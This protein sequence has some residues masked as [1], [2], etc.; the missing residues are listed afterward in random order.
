LP[1]PKQA[2][3]TVYPNDSKPYYN[4]S[5][6][7]I[8]MSKYL[9]EAQKYVMEDAYR[10]AGYQVGNLKLKERV[11]NFC[12]SHGWNCDSTTIH[13]PPVLQHYHTDYAANCGWMCSGNP[14]TSGG[15]FEPRGWG[16]SH[17]LG[18]N[19]QKFN[20]YNSASGEVSNNIYPL[21]KKWRLLI[22]LNRSNV[23]YLNELPDSAIVF[24]SLKATFKSSLT[25]EQKIAKAKNDIWMDS[26]SKSHLNRGMLYFYLQLPLIYAE[27]IQSQNPSMPEVE[28]IEAGWDIYTLMNLNRREVEASKNWSTD[29]ANLGFSTY[30]VKPAYEVY[31]LSNGVFIH[32]DYLLTVLSLITGRDQRP[33]FDFWG[34]ETTSAGRSQIEAMNLSPQPVKFYAIRCSDDLRGFRAVDMTSSNP[35]FPWPTEFKNLSDV[36]P[37][38]SA[39]TLSEAQNRS[40]STKE[41]SHK[42]A[43][44][45]MQ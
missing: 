7:T 15:G 36:T 32:H 6:K 37:V 23:G 1:D 13:E 33:L 39:N 40:I 9:A 45:S 10:L 20:V 29:K 27:V 24:D 5:S 14:I 38:E 21:H 17:E 3:T 25:A 16:E 42:T 8:D 2:Q 34:I 12:T 11:K 19:L 4:S 26:N 30:A 44:M 31:V 22:E 41:N 18:H 35:E 28:A 43:C